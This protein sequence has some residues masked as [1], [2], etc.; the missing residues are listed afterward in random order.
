M[1]LDDI[2]IR[3]NL[4]KFEFKIEYNGKVKVVN[5]K[6]FLRRRG[7][8]ID[9]I[10]VHE[11]D[12]K[13]FRSNR[14]F[15]THFNLHQS[16]HKVGKIYILQKIIKPGYYRLDSDYELPII[17]LIDNLIVECIYCSEKVPYSN[18]KKSIFRHSFPN[19]KDIKELKK[20]IIWRYLRSLP[21]I[22]ESEI[23]KLGVS[24]TKL[25]I[26]GKIDSNLRPVSHTPK[27]Q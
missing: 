26:I 2:P 23:I 1:R 10:R 13:L 16:F 7:L 8:P 4:N 15:L 3:E 17:N 5:Y 21:D 11:K 20:E 22:T 9:G 18:L 19:I 24:I 14:K 27:I 12:Y 6:R 25:K